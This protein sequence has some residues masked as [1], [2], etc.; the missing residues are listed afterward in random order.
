MPV[1]ALAV[2]GCA[3]LRAPGT[4]EDLLRLV[5][6]LEHRGWGVECL[7]FFPKAGQ[8]FRDFVADRLPLMD[9]MVIPPGDLLSPSQRFIQ[10]L[11]DGLLLPEKV[12]WAED[13]SS[14]ATLSHLP[15]GHRLILAAETVFANTGPILTLFDRP[16]G[17]SE[18]T[19][20]RIA[21]CSPDE[22]RLRLGSAS[23][24][25]A[26]HVSF[27]SRPNLVTVIPEGDDEERAAALGLLST[28][29][30]GDCLPAGTAT[31]AEAV[32]HEATTS[33]YTVAAAESCTGGLIGA[34]L[35]AIP[36]AS[37]SFCGSA[38][39]YAN[40]AKMKVLGVP[41]AVLEA[42]GAVSEACAMAMARGARDLYRSDFAVSVTGIAGPE[43]GSIR[44]PVGTVWFGLSSARGEQ[45]CLRC[46]R[47]MEREGVREWTV[48][49]AFEMLWR[50]LREGAS[51]L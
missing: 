47:S 36:G 41:R 17:L 29:F 30:E 3:S 16:V 9:C 28:L 25:G 11:K 23:D 51:C 24:L 7:R 14:Y 45:A 8:A 31:L 5:R 19:C 46:F 12:R 32:L 49:V 21:G 2:L 6:S 44:K 43:G 37:A 15:T 13:S 18:A 35:T 26:L 27:L 22:I 48:A 20:L 39:C 50:A 4:G 1:L 33:G 42:D 40:E 10:F 38:V 34:G